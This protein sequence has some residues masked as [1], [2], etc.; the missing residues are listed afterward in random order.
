MSSSGQKHV[1]GKEGR[2]PR[3]HTRV[4]T[5]CPFTAKP[6]FAT[7]ARSRL[8]NISQ[9][10]VCAT[11]CRR[12]F[13][14]HLAPPVTLLG[15]MIL[16]YL[17]VQALQRSDLRPLAGWH[18]RNVNAERSHGCCSSQYRADRVEVST[19]SDGTNRP[20]ANQQQNSASP[21]AAAGRSVMNMAGGNC[22]KPNPAG[23]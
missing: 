21:A 13:K 10:S 3:M 11:L 15:T 12:G 9:A 23:L 5:A 1:Q 14:R 4:P 6:I 16:L 2:K 20:R 7:R 17:Y 8:S 18:G 22:I 19:R